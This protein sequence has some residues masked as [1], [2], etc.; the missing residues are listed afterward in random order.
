M[1]KPWLCLYRDAILK[2]KVGKLT[3][4]Q[5]GFWSACL[6][7]SDDDGCI[8]S[9][10][11]MA[12]QLRLDPETVGNLISSLVRNAL[13]FRD[14]TKSN[15]ERHVF[16]LHDWDEHQR[17]SDHDSGGSERQKRFRE[18]QKER[19]AADPDVSQDSNALRNGPVTLSDTDTDTDTDTTLTTFVL[20]APTVKQPQRA[21]K[22]PAGSSWP[23]DAVISDEWLAA[24]MEA[25]RRNGKR[26]IDLRPEAERFA[27]HFAA[28]GKRMKDWKRAWLN[29][30]TSPFVDNLQKGT[31]NNGQ[32]QSR[33][34]A[35][36]DALRGQLTH[37]GDGSEDVQS[38]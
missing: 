16:R 11:D 7:L 32:R 17:K 4:E 19:K 5:L 1:P 20:S 38:E 21:S 30:A 37:A 31:V 10:E 13:L 27:N 23:S 36:L 18:R 15:A 9:H 3:L 14:V 34:G 6:M 24:A 12:W 2:P 33:A 29:W 8:P 35:T 26:L 28:N 22:A 25:R